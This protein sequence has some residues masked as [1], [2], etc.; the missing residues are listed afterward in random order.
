MKIRLSGMTGISSILILSVFLSFLCVA[1]C[2]SSVTGSTQPPVLMAEQARQPAELLDFI[3]LAFIKTDEQPLETL[4]LPAASRV[5]MA[6]A[7]YFDPP[8]PLMNAPQ[9]PGLSYSDSKKLV[10]IR[11]QPGTVEALAPVLASW[12]AIIEIIKTE[13]SGRTCPA[14]TGDNE[15]ALYCAVKDFEDTP[16]ANASQSVS[17]VFAF[18]VPLFSQTGT[19]SVLK[20]RYGIYPEF[21]GLGYAVKVYNNYSPMSSRIVLENSILPEYSVKNVKLS[22]AGCRCISVDPYDNRGNDPLDINLI[23]SLGSAPCTAVSRLR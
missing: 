12:P 11:C 4:G 14:P 22:E 23:W 8:L 1:G 18:A 2:R 10:A 20:N 16:V 17:K 19:A 5:F 13:F 9:Y 6:P 3:R 7:H 21:S 15:A